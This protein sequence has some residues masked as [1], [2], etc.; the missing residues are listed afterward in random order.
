MTQNHAKTDHQVQSA[1][2]KELDWSAGVE[3]EHIGV[4][5]TDGAVTLS[6]EVATLPERDAAYEAAIRVHSV[7]AVVDEI[8]VKRR[9]GGL[10]D[11][12]IARATTAVLGHQVQLAGAVVNASVHDHVITLTGSVDWHHQREAARSAVASLSG[13]VEVVNRIVLRETASAAGR[14]GNDPRRTCPRRTARRGACRPDGAGAPGDAQGPCVLLEGASRGGARGVVRPGNHRCPQRPGRSAMTS[15]ADVRATAALRRAAVRGTFAP[16]VHNT[17]PWNF[18]LR[19]GGLSIF[20]DRSRQLKVLDPAGRQL[21]IS[22]GSALMNARVSLASSGFGAMVERLPDRAQPDLL[23]RITTADQHDVRIDA[24]AAL[25]NVIEL[26]QTNR[27]RFADDQVPAEVLEV[28]EHA[29]TA[30]HSTLHLVS[31]EEHRVA[32]AMLSQKA[33]A[34]ENANPAYR[35]EI[36]AWTTTDP[37]RRDGVPSNVCAACRRSS[38]GRHSAARLRH[39]WRGV[40]A[41]RHPFR[42]DPMLGVARYRCRRPDRLAAR[43][44]GTGADPSRDHQARL[45]RQP[46]DASRGNAVRADRTSLRT[47]PIHLP[48]SPVAD[49]ARVVDSRVAASP[50]RRRAGR[51]G[52]IRPVAAYS[53]DM[54][55]RPSA[56]LQSLDVPKLELDDLIDQLVERAHGVQRAQGRLRALLHAIE[57]VSG[58]LALEAVLRNVVEAACEL[59]GARHGAL[60]VIGYDGGLEQFIHVGMDAETVARIGHLPKGHGLLGALITD[61]HPIRLQHMSDDERSTGFPD[62][63]P[64]MDSFLGVPVRVRGEVFGNLYLTDSRTGRVQRRGRG[65]RRCTRPRGR[66]G[67]QQR[68]ASSGITPSAAVARQRRWRSAPSFWRRSEKTRCG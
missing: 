33:D 46:P 40:P 53:G 51:G 50:S 10:N 18:R 23:A 28:L 25:D 32:I 2:V 34:L 62:G 27:R 20:A 21:T 4:A 24:L 6:G 41:G 26:R 43:R 52:L 14:R 59:A 13:V 7:V 5:V 16:S 30:E 39:A 3:S 35:A 56:P 55:G 37:R 61:P 68:P 38:P 57:T 11:A 1:V 9:D 48:A 12:D 64:P 19:D 49:R 42:A 60:G 44:R 47:R 54:D 58:D 22:C 31:R 67:G 65:T 8:V 45:R 17:Q 15:F 29:A 66:H 63:H 36:R